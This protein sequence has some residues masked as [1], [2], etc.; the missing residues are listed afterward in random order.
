VNT[1]GVATRTSRSEPCSERRLASTSR[2]SS[3][4]SWTTLDSIAANTGSTSRASI[5]ST[6]RASPASTA[7]NIRSI[8]P[9]YEPWAAR[10]ESTT[11]ASPLSRR[12][13]RSS[14]TISDP[15]AAVNRARTSADGSNRYFR[16]SD[17]S[18]PTAY[19]AWANAVLCAC[20]AE[21]LPAARF[22]V[23]A[24]TTA[25]PVRRRRT[26]V[27]P[28]RASLVLRALSS[29]TRGRRHTRA[30]FPA[31]AER[32]PEERFPTGHLRST[33]L[34][35]GPQSSNGSR[36]I[37]DRGQP[38]RISPAPAARDG[39]ASIRTRDQRIMS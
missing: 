7:A 8:A 13:A 27:R 30:P 23:T 19:R 15:E 6:R 34:E 39:P 37:P 28:A 29:D 21:T 26:A 4:A 14:A 38:A 16:S 3:P 10:T 17:S 31:A 32:S 25:K 20:A 11:A 36:A 1:T 33:T 22:V 12:F 18:S 24:A 35:G 9:R 5:A 2:S